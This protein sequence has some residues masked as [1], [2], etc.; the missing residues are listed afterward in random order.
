MTSSGGPG[1][2]PVA[3]TRLE[4]RRLR[5][6]EH[7]VLDGLSRKNLL[8]GRNGSGKTSLLEALGLLSMGKSFQAGKSRDLI[9]RGAEALEVSAA[10]RFPGGR[11]AEVRVRKSGSGTC[12]R[13][14]SIDVGAASELSSKLPMV[15]VTPESIDLVRAGPAVRRQVLDKT[16]FHVEPSFRSVF[17]DYQRAV[18]QR[19]ALLRGA[20]KPRDFR[21]WHEAIAE[22]AARL[23]SWRREACE[24]LGAALE[25]LP[26]PS[27]LPSIRLEY[28]RGWPE[29]AALSVLLDEALASDR[30]TGRMRY[31]P[32][33]A[34]IRFVSDQGDVRHAF[35][36]GQA[37]VV[38]TAVLLAQWQIIASAS[39]V[40]PIL[41]FDDLGAELARDYR[42]WVAERL[43]ETAAQ[44]FVTATERGLVDEG[45]IGADATVFHVEH[46]QAWRMNASGAG[47]G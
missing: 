6:I 26:W 18:S 2:E 30:Q 39:G 33:R 19:A 8:F 13:W 1:V 43:A 31:G 14:N 34:E 4:V 44:V 29:D 21:Y 12:A 45:L 37:R 32:Q 42:T 38:A 47:R 5:C 16:M 27:D 28:K 17:R 24:W 20:A 41:L 23:D 10:L 11:A 35:S 7:L 46:G 36:R 25:A 40:G 3:L 22:T 9:Q 15:V